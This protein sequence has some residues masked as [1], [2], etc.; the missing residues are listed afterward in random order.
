MR[1]Q[2][3][4]LPGMPHRP[5]PAIP[6]RMLAGRS[7]PH[8][9]TSDHPG[10]PAHPSPVGLLRTPGL[11]KRA[12]GAR[13]SSVTWGHVILH[14]SSSS[15]VPLLP[16]LP[17]PVTVNVSHVCP[18][19]PAL[20]PLH[21]MPTLTW[22]PSCRL[23]RDPPDRMSHTGSRASVGLE[24]HLLAER[25]AGSVLI[26]LRHLGLNELA[27]PGTHQPRTHRKALRAVTRTANRGWKMV[28]DGKTGGVDFKHTKV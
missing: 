6:G 3:P 5:T 16:P 18:W 28:V 8:G 12:F 26:H 27:S 22:G 17:P 9:N 25:S 2:T 19:D 20:C 23:P 11:R 14:V 10:A 13:V 4:D 21:G 1:T 15:R 7:S 24:C